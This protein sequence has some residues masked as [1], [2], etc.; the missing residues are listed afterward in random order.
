MEKKMGFFEA[1][2][3]V[4]RKS[5]V[6]KGRARRKEY[7]SWVLFSALL[8]I[9]VAVAVMMMSSSA[10]VQTCVSLLLAILMFF[11]GFSVAVRR[12]HDVD[13]S[14]WWLGGYYIVSFVYILILAFLGLDNLGEDA[15]SA[16]IVVGLLSLVFILAALIWAIVMLVWYFAKGT[17]GPNK[18][19]EDP[20]RD[21]RI[22]GSADMTVVS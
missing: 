8:N 17:D 22:D 11:P 15:T 4:F 20:K 14:G 1:V 7:W 9:V 2:S 16:T 18:Y 13:R 21:E 10:T 5:F 3:Q 6:F 19:G 12:L